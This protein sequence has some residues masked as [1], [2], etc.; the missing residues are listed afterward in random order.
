MIVI[1]PH[2]KDRAIERGATEDEIQDVVST[3]E[4]FPAKY[5]RTGFRKTVIFN[6]MWE[7]KHVKYF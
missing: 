1:H 7:G 4:S 2:A 3:G 6:E 5:G